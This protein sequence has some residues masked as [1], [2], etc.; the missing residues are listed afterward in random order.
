MEKISE[1][2][3]D[4]NLFIAPTLFSYRTTKYSTTG[5]EPFFLVY[6]RSAR[7][8]IE[9]TEDSKITSLNDRLKQLIDNVPQIR[10]KSRLQ[11]QIS[12]QKKK[13]EHDKKIK[14]EISFTIGDK[15][16]CFKAAQDQKHYGKLIPKCKVLYYIHD[17]L[18]YRAFKL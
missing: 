15:V 10:E 11:I 13:I 18:L 16:L 14:K 12:Q 4:W 9:E 7:L 1:K 6:G 3:N 2:S 5:I 17:I 8:P